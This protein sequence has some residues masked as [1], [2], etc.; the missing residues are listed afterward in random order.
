[1]IGLLCVANL[2]GMMTH[3]FF[4]MGIQARKLGLGCNAPNL[5]RVQ[6][7]RGSGCWSRLGSRKTGYQVAEF[8]WFRSYPTG[9]RLGWP[10]GLKLVGRVAWGIVG[11]LAVQGLD[12]VV[13]NPCPREDDICLSQNAQ[14]TYEVPSAI[15][16]RN[17]YIASW[18][19]RG[20]EGSFPGVSRNGSRHEWHFLSRKLLEERKLGTKMANIAIW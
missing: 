14:T 10:S 3:Y 19:A 5:P 9:V 16:V 20:D 13:T 17:R 18:A 11:P 7:M 1:M 4:C 15:R 2:A 12:R 6:N 8:A